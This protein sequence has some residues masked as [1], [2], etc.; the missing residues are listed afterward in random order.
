MNYMEIKKYDIANGPGVRTSLFVAGCTHHCKGCFNPESWDFNA[1]KEF[2]DETIDEIIESL[3][4]D[5]IKGLTLLG[6]EP[7][8]PG[9]QAALLPLVKKVKSIYPNKSIWAFSGYLFDKQIMDVMA[10]K[11]D[12]TKEFIS[13]IDVL[14][15]GEFKEEEKDLSIIFRGSRNQRIIDVKESLKQ[16]RLVLHEKDAVRLG[17]YKK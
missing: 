4:P 16:E 1:G 14:V 3:S 13:Y 9:N 5:Y 10:K 17:E 6:G 8:E 15:D 7:F 11:Y 12:F 2:T